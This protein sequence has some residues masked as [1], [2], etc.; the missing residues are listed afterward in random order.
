[1]A[2]GAR[3]ENSMGESLVIGTT[4]RG[5]CDDTVAAGIDLAERLGMA[6]HLVH[7][8]ELTPLV[9]DPYFLTPPT[10]LDFEELGKAH[11]ESMDA[12]MGRLGRKESG[13]VTR[14][15]VSGPAHRVLIELGEQLHAA[16]LVVGAHRGRFTHIVGSTASRVVR[17]SRCPVLMVRGRLAMPPD[18]VLIPVDLSPISAAALQRGLQLVAR[19]DSGR[20]EGRSAVEAFHCVVPFDF[21]VFAPRYDKPVARLRAVHDLEV[22]LASQHPSKAT[23]IT[24]AA[25]FGGAAEEIALRAEAWPADL[26]IVATHGS[27]GFERWILGSVAEG[28]MNRCLASVLTIPPAE[29]EVRDGFAP[30][31]PVSQLGSPIGSPHA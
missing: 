13:P 6:A 30:P 29:G 18:R 4:L 31:L 9:A 19:I 12:Q 8:L 5:G 17:K 1:M 2:K 26:V 25:G 14:H 3:E 11:T 22:F 27:N 10:S 15:I 21:E 24:C 16:I 20:C 28:V 7:A 23:A